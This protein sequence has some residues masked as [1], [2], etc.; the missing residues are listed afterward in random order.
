M[1]QVR[2]SDERGLAHHGWLKSRHSF[3]F[4]DYYDSKFM[5]FKSLRVINEDRISG[6]SGFGKHPHRDMEIISYVVKGALEHQD[7]MGNLAV[8]RPGEVQKLSAG[9]GMMHSEHNKS[10]NYETHF[11][12]IWITPN[13]LGLPPSYGQKSFEKQLESE[14]IV[15]VVSQDGRDGSIAIQQDAD[16]HLSKLKALDQ[17]EFKV[18]KN[19]GVWIQVIDGKLQLGEIVLKAGDAAAVDNEEI[20]KIKALDASEIMLFD[21]A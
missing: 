19:R 20:L 21:L 7:T 4:A 9:T 11:F 2:R 18:R 13:K 14:K 5:G 3:S 17:L 10:E 6:G 15:L 8:I 16:I 1:L 12:Q